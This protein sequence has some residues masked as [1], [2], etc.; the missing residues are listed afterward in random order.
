MS[1]D[2]GAAGRDGPKARE[3]GLT[4]LSGRMKGLMRLVKPHPEITWALFQRWYRRS[5]Q[6][7]MPAW[8][9]ERFVDEEARVHLFDYSIYAFEDSLKRWCGRN[10]LDFSVEPVENL[11]P[12]RHLCI[13]KKTGPLLRIHDTSCSTEAEPFICVHIPPGDDALRLF[14]RMFRHSIYAQDMAF[15]RRIYTRAIRGDPAA[16]ARN[17]VWGKTLDAG[18]LLPRGKEAVP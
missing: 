17:I 10:Q 15:Y 14:V 9:L 7:D 13:S 11:F 8:V 4:W 16:S 1:R 2:D 5:L 18:N 6:E 12:E 3:A